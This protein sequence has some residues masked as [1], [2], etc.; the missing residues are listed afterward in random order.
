MQPSGDTTAERTIKLGV[1]TLGSALLAGA[2]EVLAQQVPGSPLYIGVLPG[3]IGALR[4]LSLMLGVLTL[5]AGAL[6]PRAYEG[7][8]RRARLAST[9]IAVGVSLAI[10]A[11]TYGASNGMHGVQASDLRADAR[12][13]FFVR[14]GGLLL[15]ALAWIDIG[16]RVL[17]RPAAT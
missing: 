6:I 17:R 3:P 4:E 5:A 2:W 9:L 15:F 7:S 8:P 14:H 1:L 13:V 11:Q 12:T 10:A 16:V